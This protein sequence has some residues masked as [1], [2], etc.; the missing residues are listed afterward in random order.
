MSELCTHGWRYECS[1]CAGHG[2]ST[3][4]ASL[5]KRTLTLTLVLVAALSCGAAA[6][7]LTVGATTRMAENARLDA[8]TARNYKEAARNYAEASCM[9]RGVAANKTGGD[10][11]KVAADCIAGI[12]RVEK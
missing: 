10:G 2:S 3:T 4:K 11:R 12:E 1:L 9:W 5:N 8:E 7:A 6:G